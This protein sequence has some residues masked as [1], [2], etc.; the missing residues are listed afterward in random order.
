MDKP[1]RETVT[2]PSKPRTPPPMKNFQPIESDDDDI[3]VTP[4]RLSER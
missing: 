4:L 1:G 2:P 3:V